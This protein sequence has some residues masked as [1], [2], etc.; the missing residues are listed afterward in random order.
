MA[1]R[2]LPL[3]LQDPGLFGVRVL[4][5]SGRDGKKLFQELAAK[6]LARG[7]TR[8]ILDFSDLETVAGGAGAALAD[9]QRRLG[10]CGGEAVFVGVNEV[11][12][13]FL[14]RSFQALPLRCFETVSE[15]EADLAAAG[16]AGAIAADPADQRPVAPP[17]EEASAPDSSLD[18]LLAAFSSP[19]APPPAKAPEP[20]AGPEPHPGPGSDPEQPDSAGEGE[21]SWRVDSPSVGSAIPSA[22]GTTRPKY[23]SLPDAV[24]SIQQTPQAAEL[25]EA[26]RNLLFSNDLAAEVTY[27]YRRGGEFVDATGQ[28]RWP[29]EGKMARLLSG[30]T[31]P[32]GLLDV[33]VEELSRL[34]SRFLAEAD[35]DLILP[36]VWAGELQAAAFLKR[37]KNERE[38]GVSENFALELLMRLLSQFGDS[39][40]RDLSAP[41][42]GNR[43]QAQEKEPGPDPG[44][45]LR[46]ARTVLA[47][48]EHL[49]AAPDERVFWERLLDTLA[50][51]F[52]TR[53]V[54]CLVSREKRLVPGTCL[55]LTDKKVRELEL[56]GATG[57]KVLQG[58][59]GPAP[60]A[61]L[62]AGLAD[63]RSTLEKL[64]LTWLVPLRDGET[65]L[66]TALLG[67]PAGGDGPGV[68]PGFLGELFQQVA[69]VLQQVRSRQ[70]AEDANLKLIQILVSRLERTRQGRPGKSAAL[71]RLV[72]RLAGEVGFAADQVRD[73]VCGTLLRDLGLLGAELPS[74]DP[75]GGQE[76][77][78]Q[79]RYRAHPEEGA[80]L[81]ETLPSSRTVLD[82][83]R[84][85]HERFNGE[86]FPQGLAGRQIPLAARLV[87]VLEDFVNLTTA[88]AE[89]PAKTREQAIA[90]LRE[91]FGNRY[92]PNIVA[93]FLRVLAEEPQA[94]PAE[95]IQA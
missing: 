47:A 29:G 63:F 2:F 53:S 54:V 69:R 48:R 70:R 21:N 74:P 43:P 50:R 81:L 61:E 85:H 20:A 3:K 51:E 31:R 42:A 38:Y 12:F 35:P 55:G 94:N 95:P 76:A 46:Q 36:V 7:K 39:R 57:R 17:P 28:A 5:A 32:L 1:T 73:L 9:F 84:C 37:G 65:W 90:V 83:V 92:D 52:G 11:V 10:D 82:V 87:A 62:P 58:L 68:D 71:V 33:P 19:S 44:G 23:L 15:A 91:N 30:A 59:H 26:L 16:Q 86:G 56:A 27:C 93:V 88:T 24:T 14:V 66:G 89:R 79:R 8:L 40:Q 78:Q 4:G 49:V 25:E 77:A 80:R 22:C 41:V 72:R 13:R 18:Q 75:A 34:E 67:I 6:C 60:V 45:L 64:G